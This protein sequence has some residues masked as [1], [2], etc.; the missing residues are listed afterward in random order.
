VLFALWHAAAETAVAAL[1]DAGP[2]RGRA[3]TDI[4]STDFGN[5]AK[6]K[7][8]MPRKS[9][10]ARAMRAAVAVAMVMAIP[11]LAHAQAGAPPAN[12][13]APGAAPP[14]MAQMMASMK[15]AFA[16]FHVIGNQ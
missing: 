5:S 11:A 4:R 12:A 7:L 15:E 9:L 1:H 3:K 10:T 2:P 14:N 8:M 6:E 16:P 13:P